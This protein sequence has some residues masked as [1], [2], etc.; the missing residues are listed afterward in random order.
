MAAR[1]IETDSQGLKQDMRSWIALM[2]ANGEIQH[3]TGA[4][5]EEE[6]GG[7]V[8]IFQRKRGTPALLFDDVPGYPKGYRLLSNFLTSARRINLT[9]G[10]PADAGE[11]E[12][13][14]YWRRY[15]KDAK[16]IPPKEVKTG[17]LLE[18]VR[19]GKDINLFDIP[20]PKWHE[21]DGGFYIGTGCMVIMKDPD[22]G[23]INYGAYR[24]QAHDR[25]IA[26][27]MCSK[28]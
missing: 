15:M 16:T 6:I 2:E 8:D 19:E 10:L 27:I 5:R 22:T 21:L 4:N 18:N 13:V 14:H 11:M 9:L 25:N 28:G 1:R 3:V 7:L 24:V 23:W 12:L 17:A 26:S 20:V